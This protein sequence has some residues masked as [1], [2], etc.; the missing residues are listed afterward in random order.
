MKVRSDERAPLLGRH[1]FASQWIAQ[2]IGVE[3]E[4]LLAE[5]EIVNRS[6][7]RSIEKDTGAEPQSELA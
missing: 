2:E 5:C 6:Q 3:E 1:H 4:L 7:Q